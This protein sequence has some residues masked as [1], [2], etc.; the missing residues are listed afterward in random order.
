MLS[1]QDNFLRI[2]INSSKS[3]V[4]VLTRSLMKSTNL[5][6]LARSVCVGWRINSRM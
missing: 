6:A 1:V 2:F 5:A 3:E 4:E